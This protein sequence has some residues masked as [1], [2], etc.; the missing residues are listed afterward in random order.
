MV[1]GW[2]VTLWLTARKV[3][4]AQPERM[5]QLGALFLLCLGVCLF[6]AVWLTFLFEWALW[7]RLFIPDFALP[8]AG[9]SKEVQWVLVTL[10][11][12]TQGVLYSPMCH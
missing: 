2:L 4:F 3:G 1:L 7:V 9:I 12:H 6:C 5:R 10:L 11:K 8:Q